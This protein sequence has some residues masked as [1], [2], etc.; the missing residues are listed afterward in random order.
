M[1]SDGV[2]FPRDFLGTVR[3]IFKQLFRVLCHIYHHHYEMILN[4][5]EEAHLNT[6]F[7]HFV[8][9]AKEFDLIEKKEYLP[10]Q[11]FIEALESFGR[12]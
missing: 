3:V 9:F 2:E 1:S 11:E 12:I 4:L 10:M 6:L 8:C 7:A 5:N